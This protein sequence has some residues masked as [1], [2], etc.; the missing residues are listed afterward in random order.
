[1]RDEAAADTFSPLP[2]ID[3]ERS[4]ARRRPRVLQHRRDVQRR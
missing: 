1:V 4:D 2:L 3:D